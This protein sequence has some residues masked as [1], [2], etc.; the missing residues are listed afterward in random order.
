MKKQLE[1]SLLMGVVTS[2]T[3]GLINQ[4]ENIKLHHQ[5]ILT[6]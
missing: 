2:I 4:E 5:P 1:G 6:K 3:I